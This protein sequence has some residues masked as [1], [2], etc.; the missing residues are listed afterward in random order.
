MIP[1]KE[2]LTN[3]SEAS[4]EIYLIIG[5]EFDLSVNPCDI[6]THHLFDVL[7]RHRGRFGCTYFVGSNCSKM[8]EVF[9]R[10][11]LCFEST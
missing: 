5:R 2:L 9:V 11:S 4:K 3:G 6:I 8:F 7:L 1:K 10:K